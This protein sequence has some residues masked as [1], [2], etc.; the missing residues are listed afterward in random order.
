MS[1]S[2]SLQS[3]CA[4]CASPRVSRLAVNGTY[5]H[6]A[7]CDVRYLHPT[8]RLGRVAEEA[9]YRTHNNNLNDKGYQNFVE[10]LFRALSPHLK[11]GAQGL[12]F[13]AGEGPVLAQM[14]EQNGFPVALYDPFFWPDVTPLSKSYDFVV[15]SEVMEHLFTPRLEIEKLRAILKPEGWLGIMTLLVEPGLDFANWHYRRDPTH[16]VFY[17]RLSFEWV[18]RELDFRPPIYSGER[19]VLLQRKG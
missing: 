9:R 16:V 13:G 17:S 1:L 10:P 8:E 2:T 11:S 18:A 5:F 6:C 12:D 4:L 7:D 19:V 14:F 3:E 15:A